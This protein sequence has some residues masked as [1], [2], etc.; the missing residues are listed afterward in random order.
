M[1]AL[2]TSA[3]AEGTTDTLA[4]LFCTVSL[5][6]TRRPFQ[7]FAVSF[8]MSSPIFFGDRPR[9]PIFGARDEAAPTSPPVTR[10]NTSIT[11]LGSNLG[12]IL[13]HFPPS[14]RCWLECERGRGMA[15]AGAMH[16]AGGRGFTQPC[17]YPPFIQAIISRPMLILQCSDFENVATMQALAGQKSA[18]LRLCLRARP[19]PRCKV[20]AVATAAVSQKTLSGR[21]NDLKA[22]GKYVCCCCCCR[23]LDIRGL[24]SSSIC[25]ANWLAVHCAL[26]LDAL[27]VDCDALPPT[28]A[29]WHS[30]PSWLLVTLI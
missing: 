1:S 19:A 8:A 15:F 22:Q 4:C 17:A 9:G 30:F 28:Y 23:C 29:G 21:M 24:H 12:G 5:T 18:G 3:A 16:P 27:L 11:S 13:A 14:G 7:S 10:T 26:S 6:V 20:K 25:I 2:I